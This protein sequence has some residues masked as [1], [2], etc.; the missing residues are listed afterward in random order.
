[1]PTIFN[2]NVDKTFI[3]IFKEMGRFM[4]IHGRLGQHRLLLGY[5]SW[6]VQVM[7]SDV[8]ES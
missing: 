5:W 6:V 1:M 2:L 3:K 8:N 7:V 4:E